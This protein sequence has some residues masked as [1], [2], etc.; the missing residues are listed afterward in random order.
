[1]GWR[2]ENWRALHLGCS[3]RSMNG[4]SRR[5]NLFFGS[6]LEAAV[7]LLDE[8]VKGEILIEGEEA[9]REDNL[10][11][12]LNSDANVD[13]WKEMCDERRSEEEL[14]SSSEDTAFT[15]RDRVLN[16]MRRPSFEAKKMRSV[17]LEVVR[18]T[19]VQDTWKM[20]EANLEENGVAFFKAIFEIAPGRCSSFL[21]ATS[22]TCTSRPSSGRTR[23]E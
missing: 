8:S 12:H 5:G 18:N 22:R 1:M 19:K 10:P 9:V 16:N 14:D 17:Q 13:W 23:R 20:V 6:A 7:K 2:A 21:S 4:E 15:P 11:S 3:T